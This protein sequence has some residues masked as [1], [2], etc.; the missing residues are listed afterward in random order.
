MKA[1]ELFDLAGEVAFVTGASSGLGARFAETLAA[2]GAKVVLAARR[3][4]RLDALAARIGKDAMAVA[5][6]V[7]DRSMI[8][9]AFDAAEAQFGPVTLLVN[10]AGI[11]ND[12]RFLDTTDEQWDTTMATNLDGVWFMAREAARRMAKAGNGGTII[13]I[14]SI[15]GFRVSK[16]SA[17]YCVSKAAV[18]QMTAALAL[19]LAKFKIRVN[20]IAPGYIMSEMTEAFLASPESEASRKA[21]PMRMTGEPSDLDGALLLLA[22]RKAGRFMTGAT[23]AVD[24]GHL[25]A[26]V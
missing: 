12:D 8:P 6:D 26:F 11:S 18:V 3:T 23:I 22:S 13:N 16:A 10:N 1:H 2:H 5:L 7:A 25:T 9:K 24:G 20:A 4:D 14:A 19:D 21:I 17:P 15:L